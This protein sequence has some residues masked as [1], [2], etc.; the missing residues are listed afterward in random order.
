MHKVQYLC[1]SVFDEGQLLPESFSVLSYSIWF[2]NLPM[3]IS[4]DSKLENARFPPH[5]LKAELH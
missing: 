2:P 3:T 1:I 5:I 4:G